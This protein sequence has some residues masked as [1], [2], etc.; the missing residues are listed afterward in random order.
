[1]KNMMQNLFNLH[2]IFINII[3]ITILRSQYFVFFVND[4]NYFRKIFTKKTIFKSALKKYKPKYL[5]FF[6]YYINFLIYI[7]RH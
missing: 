5:F 7:F 1:M 6:H 4:S 2:E 3:F